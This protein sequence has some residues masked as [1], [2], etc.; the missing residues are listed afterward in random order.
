MIDRWRHFRTHP[1]LH[2]E[3]L[4]VHVDRP[5]LLAGVDDAL[6]AV[7][8]APSPEFNLVCE[9]VATLDGVFAVHS[10]NLR[11]WNNI[12]RHAKDVYDDEHDGKWWQQRW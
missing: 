5:G 10:L 12:W 3:D 6:G 7:T 1:E 8:N 11:T 4:I 9:M 2:L